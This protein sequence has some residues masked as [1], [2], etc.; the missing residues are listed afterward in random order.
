M[1][2]V[3]FLGTDDAAAACL[4]RL[5]ADGVTRPA[6]LDAT[7]SDTTVSLVVTP[8]DRRRGRRGRPTPTL[9]RALAE[10]LGVPVH[11][12]ANANSPECLAAIRAADPWLLVVVSF[13]QILRDELLAIPARGSLNLHYSILP[14]WRGAAPVQRAMIAGDTTVGACVQQMV[15]KLDAG[16]VFITEET[17]VGERETAAQLRARLTEI[18]SGL[19]SETVAALADGTAAEP[20]PQDESLVTLARTIRK[21][22]GWLAFDAE[23]GATL[24]RRVRALQP[25]PGTRAVLQVGDAE[26]QVIHVREALPVGRDDVSGDP[27]PGVVLEAGPGGIVVAAQGGALRITRV[28]RQGGREV[29]VRAFLNGLGVS[30]GD[31]FLPPP[32]SN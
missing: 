20:V 13:G 30:V 4:R 32:S 6:G 18:G 3:V 8:P 14:R 21:E 19:L 11:P 24:D 22:E 17:A 31:R 25:W 27:A 7:E 15:R 29:D 28:Q 1:S 9:V 16:P 26:P 5:V 2:G 10:E 12:T 23:D